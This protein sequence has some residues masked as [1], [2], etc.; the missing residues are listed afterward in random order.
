MKTLFTLIRFT[1]LLAIC[2]L[3]FTA[4]SYAQDEEL[5]P[6]PPPPVPGI[7]SITNVAIPAGSNKCVG[8]SINVNITLSE[9]VSAPTNLTISLSNYA[10]GLAALL[11]CTASDGSMTYTINPG[12]GTSITKSYTIP[13]P[14]AANVLLFPDRKIKATIPSGS[15]CSSNASRFKVLMVLAPTANTILNIPGCVGSTALLDAGV[16]P[17]N[18]SSVS[19]AASGAGSFSSSSAVSPTFIPTEGG[20]YTFT[21]SATA[22]NTLSC[23]N[24]ATVGLFVQGVAIVTPESPSICVGATINL[25]A[26][27]GGYFNLF[28]WSSSGNGNF[29]STL[30]NPNA[31][32]TA[33]SAGVA[34]FS[35]TGSPLTGCTASATATVNIDPLPIVTISGATE[36]CLG[37]NIELNANGADMYSWSIDYGGSYSSST[38]N[39]LI[40]PTGTNAGYY[41]YTV[42]GSSTASCTATATATVFV[43]PVI[44]P[45]FAPICLLGNPL[46]LSASG[47]GSYSWRGPN[48]FSSTM[49]SPTPKPKSTNADAGIYSVTVTATNACTASATLQVYIGAGDIVITNNST[50]CKGGTIKLTATAVA[51]STYK[52]TKQVGSTVY[53]GSSVNIPNAKT[54]NAGLY[55]VFATAPNGCIGKKET[56]VN[57][58][59]IACVGTRLATDLAEEQEDG[60]K[61][62]LSENPTNGRMKVSVALSQESRVQLDWINLSGTKLQGWESPNNQALH[63]FDIDVSTS[64]D[65]LYLL[66]AVTDTGQKSLRVVKSNKQ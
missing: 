14:N 40:Q 41:Y 3:A 45:R 10:T 58:S 30:A 57:V 66:R 63:E 42:T 48:N 1:F 28:S 49:A 9:A 26:S 44:N 13:A 52:W 5:E 19:W 17:T 54:S 29:S 7:V 38:S 6:A 31:T 24:S 23:T 20:Q 8:S 21:V 51:G 56:L 16:L 4:T 50:V 46:S 47:G 55:I 60:I 61:L 15:M 35:V 53:Y 43:G 37:T 18:S 11:N 34:T 33:T 59:P 2:C 22:T 65:G 32:F 36:I 12:D 62:T 39:P 25:S 64:A 27:G